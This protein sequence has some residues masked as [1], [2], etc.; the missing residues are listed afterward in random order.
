M[1]Q[2]GAEPF[3]YIEPFTCELIARRHS[4]SCHYKTLTI[5]SSLIGSYDWSERM[6]QL[7]LCSNGLLVSNAF[8]FRKSWT[9][10]NC[11]QKLLIIF[12]YVARAF[13][14]VISHCAVGIM[15]T[16][17]IAHNGM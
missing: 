6:L 16:L 14:S 13:R 3:L 15:P 8:D 9:N 17:L 7:R 10:S 5:N 12:R 4:L 11:R 2:L 1:S